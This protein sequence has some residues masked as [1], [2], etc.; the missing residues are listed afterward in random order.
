[1]SALDVNINWGTSLHEP[2]KCPANLPY[3]HTFIVGVYDQHGQRCAVFVSQTCTDNGGI[4][5][6]PQFIADAHVTSYP[7]REVCVWADSSKR[8]SARRADTSPD[9][10]TGGR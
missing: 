7:G 2:R 8:P 3:H 10:S 5:N 6:L 1:M 4:Y 9:A